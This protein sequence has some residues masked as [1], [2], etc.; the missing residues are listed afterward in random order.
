MEMPTLSFSVC[1]KSRHSSECIPIKKFHLG[2]F[3]Y[4]VQ[5]FHSLSK[6]KQLSTIITYTLFKVYIMKKTRGN[7]NYIIQYVINQGIAVGV[8]IPIKKFHLE[9]FGYFVHTFHS[10]S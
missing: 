6:T 7:A 8:Y 1:D 3:G 10:L 9:K 2:K 4:F 5:P